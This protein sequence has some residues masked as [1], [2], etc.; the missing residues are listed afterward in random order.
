MLVIEQRQ[1]AEAAI[2]D[3]NETIDGMSNTAL[4]LVPDWLPGR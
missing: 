3:A 1:G 2:D 4:Y